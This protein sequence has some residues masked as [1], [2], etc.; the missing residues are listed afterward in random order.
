MQELTDT[1]VAMVLS[2][3]VV[4]MDRALRSS[5][6]VDSGDVASGGGLSSSRLLG[7]AGYPSHRKPDKTQLTDS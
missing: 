6:N 3:L 7:M 2:D 1:A 5:D 4:I